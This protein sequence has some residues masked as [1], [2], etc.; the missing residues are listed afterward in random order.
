MLAALVATAPA[1]TAA[2]APRDRLDVYTGVVSSGQLSEF[3]DLGIDRH[4]L[5]L[6]RVAA[7]GGKALVRVEAILSGKQAAGLRDEGL[8][9]APKTVD[10]KTVAQRATM[11]AQDGHEV[12]RK[13]SGPGGLKEEF[14]Q[15]AA[16]N[17]KITKLISYGESL[18]GQDIVALK[19]SKNADRK[20][21]G[22]R[23][24]VLYLGASMRASG[25]RPR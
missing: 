25:S 4:E 19:V 22:S 1:A 8:D 2:Q 18:N 7:R 3:V 15:A 16:D 6:S 17:P 11:L 21:D 10:G 13:Y 9:L 24:S 12:F 5:E 23:P 14:E 20:R